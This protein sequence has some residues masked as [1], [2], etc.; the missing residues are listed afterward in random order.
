MHDPAKRAGAEAPR[1]LDIQSNG[2]LPQ[3]CAKTPER[4]SPLRWPTRRGPA[5]PLEG[6]M[7][8]RLSSSGL[9]NTKRN[10]TAMSAVE[11]ARRKMNVERFDS[12]E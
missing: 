12:L 5:A 3:R 4:P 9:R 2:I 7:T 6:T 1:Q 11:L 10:G 8:P